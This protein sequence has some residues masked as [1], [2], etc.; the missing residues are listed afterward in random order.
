MTKKAITKN[1]LRVKCIFQWIGVLS[2]NLPFVYSQMFITEKTPPEV[3]ENNTIAKEIIEFLKEKV[4]ITDFL[5]VYDK[6]HSSVITKR[7]RRKRNTSVLAV[8]NPQQRAKMRIS[9]HLR[10]KRSRKRKSQGYTVDKVPLRENCHIMKNQKRDKSN[11]KI[12]KNS[13]C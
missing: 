9:K 13:A 2:Q 11:S 3:T 5:Q 4:G 6:V 8:I 1:E 10:Q 7:Q 12:S